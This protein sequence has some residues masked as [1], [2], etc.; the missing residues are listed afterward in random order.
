MN[1]YPRPRAAGLI[2]T[3][4]AASL[5]LAG[6]NEPQAG[7]TCNPKTDSSYLHTWTDKKGHARSL[8]LE[9]RPVGIDTTG[10]GKTRWEWVE[11]K[12]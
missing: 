2:A 9:C 7:D 1:L 5:L 8:Q 4:A 11:V 3:L 6:C 12:K 10:R